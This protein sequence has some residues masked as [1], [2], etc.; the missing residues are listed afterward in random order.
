MERNENKQY[1]KLKDR[2]HRQMFLISPEWEKGHHKMHPTRMI[3]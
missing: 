2:L 3:Y 1:D